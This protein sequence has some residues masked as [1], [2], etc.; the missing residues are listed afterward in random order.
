MYVCDDNTK[1][2]GC[3]WKGSAGRVVECPKLAPLVVDHHYPRSCKDNDQL[4]TNLVLSYFAFLSRLGDD[5]A[6]IKDLL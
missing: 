5:A 6:K 3:M 4:V 1:S 2:I